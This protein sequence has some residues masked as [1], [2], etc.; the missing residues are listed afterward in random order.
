[1][2]TT[3]LPVPA[4]GDRYADTRPDTADRIVTV[5]RVWDT[6]DADGGTAVAYHWRDN[7][8]GLCGGALSL[9]K[10]REIYR[11][12]ADP[13]AALSPTLRALRD[14]IAADPGAMTGA[15]AL[16]SARTVLA[17]HARELA[18]LI[19]GDVFEDRKRNPGGGDRQRNH[20]RRGAMLSCRLRL[21]RYADDLDAAGG[22]Q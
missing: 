11:A 21:D 14:L 13:D 6:E 12:E 19:H 10:F 5:T 18:E 7:V 3:D 17:V 20:I 2:T 22:G 9:R 8:L 1:M 4:V 16:A 15:E